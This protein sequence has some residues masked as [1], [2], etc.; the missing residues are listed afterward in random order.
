MSPRMRMGERDSIRKKSSLSGSLTS[1]PMTPFS[2]RSQAAAARLRRFFRGIVFRRRWARLAKILV[3][4]NAIVARIVIEKEMALR[5]E[6]ALLLFRVWKRRNRSVFGVVQRVMQEHGDLQIRA[7]LE[8][9]CDFGVPAKFSSEEHVDWQ[10][11]G[12]A[13]ATFSGFTPLKPKE[14][15][16][17]LAEIVQDD[18]LF[19]GSNLEASNAELNRVLP[20]S[21]KH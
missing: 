16:D 14:L 10:D 21:S 17:R 7:R 9:A 6:A 4:K 19:E 18:T 5:R 3:V 11:L 2:P 13:A 15:T 12:A 8:E 20:L 1:I